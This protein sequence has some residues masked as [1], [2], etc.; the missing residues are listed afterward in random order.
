MAKLGRVAYSVMIFSLIL[1]LFAR[2]ANSR[3]PMLIEKRNLK[4][5]VDAFKQLAANAGDATDQDKQPS[6]VSPGGP[7]PHHHVLNN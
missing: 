3:S 7:D 5:L 6:R 1:I 2:G 4:Q